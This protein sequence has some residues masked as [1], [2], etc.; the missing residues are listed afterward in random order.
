MGGF[1]TITG[2]AFPA[3]FGRQHLGSIRGALS[4]ITMI[5]SA[6][7]PLI[8]GLLWSDKYSYSISFVV[9]GLAWIIGGLLPLL[10]KSPA[11]HENL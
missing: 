9:F 3:Y 2:V 1:P 5:V 6:S 8:G 10:L 4:P 11:D 7:S